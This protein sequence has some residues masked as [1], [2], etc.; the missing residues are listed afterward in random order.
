M[1]P[2]SNPASPARVAFVLGFADVP[3]DGAG[4]LGAVVWAIAHPVLPSSRAAAKAVCFKRMMSYPSDLA[5]CG[6]WGPLSVPA[7]KAASGKVSWAPT[8]IEDALEIASYVAKS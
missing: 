4:L 6:A 3:A 1:A 2:R 7:N 5:A 8:R